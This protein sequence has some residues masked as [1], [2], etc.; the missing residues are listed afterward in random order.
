MENDNEILRQE[1]VEKITEE[2]VSN[3]PEAINSREASMHPNFNVFKQIARKDKIS[4]QNR[5]NNTDFG[6]R[7]SKF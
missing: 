3:V 1:I 6:S 4:G 2:D 7:S 5:N